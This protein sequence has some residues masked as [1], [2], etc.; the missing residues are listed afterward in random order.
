MTLE[1]IAG[2]YMNIEIEG[3]PDSIF[4]PSNDFKTHYLELWGVE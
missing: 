3:G 2:R 4:V 1:P